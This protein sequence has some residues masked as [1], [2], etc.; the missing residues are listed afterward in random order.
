MTKAIV[1][2]K[3]KKEKVVKKTKACQIIKTESSY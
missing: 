3:S 1:K 2:R